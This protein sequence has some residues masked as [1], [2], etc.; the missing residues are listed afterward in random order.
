MSEPAAKIALIDANS[1]LHR[2]F[3]A[4]PE[5]TSPE[6]VSVGAVYGF[7]AMLLRVIKQLSPTHVVVAWDTAAPTFRHQ[8]Y[9]AYKQHRPKMPSELAKQIE[10]VH[11]IVESMNMP[12]F[13]VEGYEADDLVGT[14]AR[15]SFEVDKGLQVY[16]VTGDMD[17]LQLVNERVFVHAPRR[18]FSDVVTYDISA[19]GERL[20]GLQPGQVVDY[21]A[22]RGDP[23]DNIPGVRGIGEKTAIELLGKFGSLDGVYQHLSELTDRQRKLLV[24]G[25]EDAYLSQR[26][27]KIDC[28]AP[29]KLDLSQTRTR[30]FDRARVVE[31]FRRFGFRSFIERL[32]LA[33][34]GRKE[35][36]PS[37]LVRDVIDLTSRTIQPAEL[38]DRLGQK[39][40]MEILEPVL[41]EDLVLIAH[42]LTGWTDNEL[43]FS[44]LVFYYLGVVLVEEGLDQEIKEIL[45][46]AL[47]ERLWLELSRPENSQIQKLFSEVELPL[48]EVLRTMERR[49]IRVDRVL[50]SKYQE[51][52][53]HKIH[54][55]EQQIFTEVGHEFNLNSPKQ[56]EE[57]L[58]D[59]LHLPVIK[60][61]KTQR[62]T[63][64]VVLQKLSSLHPVADL[65]LQ[66][67]HWYKLQSTYVEPLFSMLDDKDRVHTTFNQTRT[68]SGR[69]SSDSPNLQNIPRDVEVGLRRVFVPSAGQVL[70]VADYSQIELRL[71]AHLS[72]DQALLDS[73][74]SGQDI[75]AATAARILNKFIGEVTRE[76][77]NLGKTINFS[78]MYGI[79]AH[80][81]SET[82]RV[83]R[84]QAQFYIDN[85]YKQYPGVR[86]WQDRLLEKVRAEGFVETVYGRRRYLPEINSPNRQKRAAVER[87]AINHPLQGTQADL[88]KKAMVRLSK[89][90]KDDF[91][92]KVF[93][94][95]QVH[96][97]LVFEVDPEV[98]S[99]ISSAIRHEMEE[100]DLFSLPIRVDIKQ[101]ENWQDLR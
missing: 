94:L 25:Q 71:M 43:A 73:F 75:H 89:L 14:L 20:G 84:T 40:P 17:A 69:L 2:A 57:V 62:S 13:A 8:Q 16:I 99:S 15:Q 39:W 63:S 74:A 1:L 81:L 68:A 53:R 91:G 49:G 27:A 35:V 12:Q 97:E 88:I 10:G 28:F 9:L 29:I 59:G 98:V 66:Y 83:D 24:E 77:R 11:Q 48:Q 19:V 50:L 76:D 30:D 54:K 101:G 31:I 6:G 45:L 26:L 36:E 42:L 61:T 56:L 34:V 95:V 23:S 65:I 4:M 60:K 86:Q 51:K 72:Q 46:H 80:G 58:F 21:K 82:L 18:S 64:E 90:I 85:F 96:D 47:K 32:P 22:L 37:N 33:E 41:W 100:V 38:A 55:I 7:T 5:L 79:T 52:W 67:R 92:E 93:L 44:H 87:V 78:L 70:L 3:H